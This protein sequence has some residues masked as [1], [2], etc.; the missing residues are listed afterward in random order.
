MSSVTA[1]LRRMMRTAVAAYL[2]P[3]LSS[4]AS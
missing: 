4:T 2:D 1:L 3:G